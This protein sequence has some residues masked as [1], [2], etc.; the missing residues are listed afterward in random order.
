MPIGTAPRF[1]TWECHRLEKLPYGCRDVAISMNL[2]SSM[3]L[4][5]RESV[6]ETGQMSAVETRQKSQQQCLLLRQ[7]RCLLLRQDRCLLLRQDR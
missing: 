6:I 3:F 5:H 2:A 1:W 4:R 7:D